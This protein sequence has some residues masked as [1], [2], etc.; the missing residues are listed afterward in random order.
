MC[1][2]RVAVT[3]AL[4]SHLDAVVVATQEFHQLRARIHAEEAGFEEIG[5]LAARTPWYLFGGYWIR[6]FAGVCRYLVLGY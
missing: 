5:A 4:G 3:T 1:R 2:Y 6:D